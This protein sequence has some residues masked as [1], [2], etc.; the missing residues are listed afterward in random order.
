M[1]LLR[2]LLLLIL[3][4]TRIT[5]QTFDA[6]FNK[7][8]SKLEKNDDLK[9]S[10]FQKLVDQY[11]NDLQKYPDESAQLF[12]YKGNYQYADG[13]TDDA[14]KSFNGAFNFALQAKD[15]TFKYYVILAFARVTYNTKAYDRSEEYYR[16]ALPGMAVVY[17]ANSKEY[18]KIYFEYVR[19]LVQLGRLNEAKPLLEAL[20]YYYETLNMF[21]D[22]TYLAVMGNL[23][24]ILQEMG[25][26]RQA[27]SI[28]KSVIENDKLLKQGDTLE[29]SIMLANI[30]EAYREMGSYNEALSYLQNTKRFMQKY[31]VVNYDQSASI[32]NNLGLLYKSTGDYKNSEI[33][34]NNALKLYKEGELMD[35]EPYCS[36]LS[37]KADLMRLLNRKDEALK[38]LKQ[39]L[40]TREK[41]FGKNSENYANALSTFGLVAFEYDEVK[42]AQ[43][44]FEEALGIYEKTVS[45]THQSYANC[46]NNLSGCYARTGDLMKAEDYKLQAMQ[47]IEKTLGKE[48]F[49]Y[50]SFAIGAADVFY[51]NKNNT[52]AIAVLTEAKNLAKRKFGTQHDLYIRSAISLAAI[53][54]MSEKY[55]ES[56][57]E[58][59]EAIGL[60]LKTINEFFYTMN[61]EDQVVYLEELQGE[62]VQYGNCLFGY[63]EKS[64]KAYIGKH[65]QSYFNYHLIMKN[66]LNKNT[67]EFQKQLIA[68]SND[69]V[70]T[71]YPKYLALK[72]SLNEL[73]RSDF[74]FNEQDSI[75]G[76][77]NSLETKL[78]EAIGYKPSEQIQFSTLKNKL[79]ANEAL[80]DICWYYHPLTDTS[81][82]TRYA[83]FIIKNNSTDPECI[84]LSDGKKDDEKNIQ[85]YNDRMEKE[86]LDT[87]SY[88]LFFKKMASTLSSCSKLFISTTGDYSRINFQTLFD[89]ISRQYLINKMDIVYMPDLS[90][91]GSS[92]TNI[93]SNEAQLYGNPDFNYDFR[94]KVNAK[95]LP[96]QNKNQLLAKRLG[97]TAITDLPGTETELK[98]IEKLM[99][100]SN[101]KFNAYTR[102]KASEENLRKVNSPKLLH[103][104][105]HGYF[106]KE[107]ETDD[108]KFL[109]YNVNA[110]KQ[111]ADVRSGLILAG[112]A[113][114]TND[115]AKGN[116][117]KDGLLT[118]REASLLNLANTDLVVLSACQTG[119]G[120]ETLNMGVI[121]LQ[122]AFSNAGAK[123]LILSLW[124]VDD[125]A[126]QLLM[127]KFYEYWL[128]NATN[129]NISIAFKKA[130]LDVKQKYAHP[131]YWGA[132]VLIKN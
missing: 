1:K 54:Y 87:L 65:Y 24:Y 11:K 35:T 14:I 70:K 111:L 113:I 25:E 116:A 69:F 38:L 26:Y 46:L 20:K 36:A 44:Y 5:A 77:I 52:R 10:D 83:A 34:F 76:L 115:T 119:L 29:H 48:H 22:N 107:V 99:L 98:G 127:V 121:G 53:K 118:S 2:L 19:L 78:R 90:T 125:N 96:K 16:Y 122:Q 45:K 130:Q 43:Q 31:K 27:L 80:V 66:L 57:S 108:D 60:K 33:S 81:G 102:E 8:Y 63:T 21:D 97:L 94:K 117:S 18:T 86:V 79:K 100:Q 51:M 6:D 47:I 61:R 9:V 12:Y 101:W 110:F 73:Y 39:S 49:K 132:F 28:Y 72:N 23:G 84:L 40:D 82:Q 104:A 129:E 120:L 124:P 17:G 50:I 41:Y 58:F 55:E 4:S 59:E 75:H 91:F 3:A 37:N 67:T 42:L 85:Q 105:T 30:G 56:L 126:T 131:Y 7:L 114:N 103:I 64:P 106:L 95:P 88:D 15:T 68:S 32:E 109:G 128:P 123:N 89:P 93:T 112:A 92:N 62:M 74:T 71:N 13:K